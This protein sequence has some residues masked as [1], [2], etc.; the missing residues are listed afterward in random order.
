MT[1]LKTTIRQ[2]LQVN[3]LL[4]ILDK[5]RL[6]HDVSLGHTWVNVTRVRWPNEKISKLELWWES[7]TKASGGMYIDSWLGCRPIIRVLPKSL[8]FATSDEVNSTFFAVRSPWMIW[9]LYL[10]RYRRPLATSSN[11]DSFSISGMWGTVLRRSSRLPSSCSITSRGRGCRRPS[12][13]RKTRPMNRAMFGWW[14]LD[15]NWHSFR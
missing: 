14:R 10:L 4:V 1:G 15:F 9:G 13:G 5:H 8:I 7:I 2:H 6:M 3:K 12:S 11:I